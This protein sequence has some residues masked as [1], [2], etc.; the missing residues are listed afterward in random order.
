ML[1]GALEAG[2]TKMVCAIGDEKG[3]I[4][5]QVSIPTLEPDKTIPKII[6]YFKDKDIK[7]LGV[8]CFGPIDPDPS[9]K[10][11]GYITSTPK[12]AWKDYDIVG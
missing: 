4:K 3:Q 6:D 8:A 11:Y 5:E 7:A 10:T 9:S 12:L 1:Y 2:G